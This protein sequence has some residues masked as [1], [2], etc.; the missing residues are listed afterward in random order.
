MTLPAV[1]SGLRARRFRFAA[2]PA[3]RRP[4]PR[5]A[6]LLLA[7]VVA[8]LALAPVA[9]HADPLSPEIW[10]RLFWAVARFIR[11]LLNLPADNDCPC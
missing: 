5:D 2:T 3:R 6:A 10:S 7:L 11:L 4:H 9:A 8:T 1:A